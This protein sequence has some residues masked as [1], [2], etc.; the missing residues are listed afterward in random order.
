[1]TLRDCPPL[2]QWRATPALRL[3]V[4]LLAMLLAEHHVAAAADPSATMAY[5]G[6][7]SPSIDPAV[8]ARSTHHDSSRPT[9]HASSSHLP[10][11][12]APTHCMALEAVASPPTPPV[13]VHVTCVA[14]GLETGSLQLSTGLTASLGSPALVPPNTTRQALL[15]IFLH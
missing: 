9:H 5:S 11:P 1:M 12:S 14:V 8:G 7:V 6:L 2:S 15:Q 10:A 4:L 13:K 3:L